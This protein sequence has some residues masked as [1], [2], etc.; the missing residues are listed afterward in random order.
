MAENLDNDKSFGNFS[1]ENTMEMGMGNSELLNDLM[2]P[3]TSTSS[4]DDIQD[5]TE[6]P[7]APKTKKTAKSIGETINEANVEKK[8][9]AE[10]DKKS[11]TD[12]Y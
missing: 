12:F 11:L 10:N 1:I 5:I 6:E 2:S 3:E 4:P 7:A 9:E 8:D